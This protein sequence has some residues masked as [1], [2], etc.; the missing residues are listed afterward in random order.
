M[1]IDNSWV[2]KGFKGSGKSKSGLADVLGV[3]NGAISEILA[4]TRRVQADEVPK[5]AAY[6][7]VEPPPHLLVKGSQPTEMEIHVTRA[8][9]Q[10]KVV[11]VPLLSWVSAGRLAEAGQL[12]PN[13]DVPLLAFSDLGRGDYFALKVQGDSMDRISPEGS[14]IVVNRAETKLIRGKPYVFRI[15]GET[16]Y[17]IWENSD[18]IDRLEPRSFNEN[19]KTIFVK[20]NKGFGVVG[21]VRRTMFDL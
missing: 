4:N 11:L 7:G 9:K 8:E 6:L 5:V 15:D 21:R 10:A 16:T 3:R 19:N 18:A 13:S 14:T 17:K 20:K 12:I 2:E 1:Q